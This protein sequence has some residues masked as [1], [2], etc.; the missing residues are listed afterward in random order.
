MF[1]CLY[2]D[3]RGEVCEGQL[4]SPNQLQTTDTEMSVNHINNVTKVAVEFNK[5]VNTIE[6]T[7]KD[8]TSRMFGTSH[9]HVIRP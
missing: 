9:P 7:F 1:Q 6:F 5:K 2:T 8:G 4:H 3:D